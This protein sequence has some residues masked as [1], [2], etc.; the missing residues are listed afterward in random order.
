MMTQQK[1]LIQL[2]SIAIPAM[3]HEDTYVP[4]HLRSALIEYVEDGEYPGPELEGILGNNLRGAVAGA[5]TATVVYL[6][7]LVNWV[8]KYVPAGAKGRI[9]DVHVWSGM[10]E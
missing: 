5:D 1:Q 8:F 2:P 6:K 9:R 3:D 7:S 4:E 10:N